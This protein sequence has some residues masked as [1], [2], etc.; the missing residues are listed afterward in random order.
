MEMRWWNSDGRQFLGRPN[1]Y[2]MHIRVALTERDFRRISECWR[3]I[4]H[5]AKNIVW[6]ICDILWKFWDIFSKICFWS[7]KVMPDSYSTCQ[8]SSKKTRTTLT[9]ICMC[10]YGQMALTNSTW[11]KWKQWTK[12]VIYYGVQNCHTKNLVVFCIFIF[13]AKHFIHKLVS[14]FISLLLC[15][16]LTIEI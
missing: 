7:A 15:W 16:P 12:F 11:F 13:G 4:T 9:Y 1:M 6:Q 3:R 8:N 2:I 10:V 5:T 14:F